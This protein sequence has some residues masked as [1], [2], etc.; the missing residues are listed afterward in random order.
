MTTIKFY[1]AEEVSSITG[2]SRA[3]VWKQARLGMIPHHRL[4][5]SYRWTDEDLAALAAQSAVQP[6]QAGRLVPLRRGGR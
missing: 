5:G 3:W 6:K 4:G 2:M 1:T